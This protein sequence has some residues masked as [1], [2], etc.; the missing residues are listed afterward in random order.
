MDAAMNWKQLILQIAVIGLGSNP[1]TAKL[2]PFVV[3]GITE[4]E[5]MS[6]ASGKD[7]LA[8]AVAI[9]KEG[10]AAANA[11][12]PGTINENAAHQVI[13]SGISAVVDSV[14]VFKNAKLITE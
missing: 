6:G 13:E 7:K 11:V 2:V 4:A 10:I 14:N 1:K 5:A 9:T 12:R 8:H 3:N